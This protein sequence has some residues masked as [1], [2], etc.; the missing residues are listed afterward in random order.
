MNI[1]NISYIF[2]HKCAY[3]QKQ[4]QHKISTQNINYIKRHNVLLIIS[5][6]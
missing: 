3:L 1:E 5:Y 4:Y 6:Y 2:I